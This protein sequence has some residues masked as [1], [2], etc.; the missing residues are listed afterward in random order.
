MLL[1]VLLLSDLEENFRAP[2]VSFSY[3]ALFRTFLSSLQLTLALAQLRFQLCYVKILS[4][5][6]LIN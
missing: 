3:T 1:S 4:A 6:S 5:S 2:F